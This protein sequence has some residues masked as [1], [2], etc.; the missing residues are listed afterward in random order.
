MRK[1][2][3]LS[4][5]AVMLAA[6]LVGPPALAGG[7][8]VD[9]GL[10]PPQGRW[11]IRSQMR[12]MGREAPAA[13][14]DMSMERLVVPVVVVHGA[15][16]ALT[17]GLRQTYDSRTMTM[18]GRETDTSGFGDL[19]LFTKYR[20]LRVNTRRYTLGLSPVLAV[21]MRTGAEDVSGGAYNLS[22]GFNAS[23]RSGYWAVDVDL[24][25]RFK[26]I[27]GVDEA[28]PEPGDEVALHVAFARQVPVGAGGETALAPVLELSWLSAQPNEMDGEDLP[29]SGED[30]FAVAPGLKFTH[31]DV[32]V[33][34]LVR[35]PV[36]QEQ[37]GMQSEVGAMYL[38]G[39]RRM[40]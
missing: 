2:I 1:T 30:V 15:T 7:I 13:M 18:N 40:F 9:S 11:M 22:A 31:G 34:G 26:G 33:E 5:L 17:L 27:A 10:T 23:G 8:S 24:D 12:L 3:L 37:R 35:L 39:V 20:I 38:L 28:D 14:G 32:I 21:D 16:P 6:S 19:H 4:I 29:D 36:S 25:Y